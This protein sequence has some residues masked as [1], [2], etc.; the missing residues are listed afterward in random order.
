MIVRKLLFE[1]FR[2]LETNFIEPK[3]GVNVIYG[4][5]AQGKTNLL[6]SLWLFSGNR[7]F[8]GARD[9]ELIAFGKDQAKIS[10]DFLSE[11]REQNAEII[12]SNSKKEYFLNKVCKNSASDISEAFSAV[13][14]SPEHLTL[15]KGG[16]AER[17]KF[18]DIAIFQNKRKYSFALT[19][20]NQTLTQRN[21]LLKDILYHSELLGTLEIWDDRLATFG[22]YIIKE[23]L[24]YINNLNKTA[25]QF[26][27]GISG[28]KEELELSYSESYVDDVESIKKAILENLIKSRKDDLNDRYTNIGPHRED[29]EITVNGLKART[30]ASQGQQRSAVLSLKLSEASI[31]N[32]TIGE[33]PVILL[34]DVLSEL[35]NER[36]DFLLNHLCGWQVFVTCCEESSKEHLKNGRKFIVNNGKISEING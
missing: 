7:S 26:H 19:K 25:K 33:K 8:R 35:D 4:Q 3:D 21:A 9:S 17:R 2:N 23:R 20:Y 18:L 30:F 32:E 24:D 15:V 36:Q 29:L 12:V 27:S 34:D 11:N 1:N 5:N 16:P 31:L 22:S 10:L 13:V 14:F 6:E 28:G